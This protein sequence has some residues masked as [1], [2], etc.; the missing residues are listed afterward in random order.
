MNERKKIER[1]REELY[2]DDSQT[3][4]TIEVRHTNNRNS[5]KR[6]LNHA[7]INSEVTWTLELSCA[8]VQ[9]L[10]KVSVTP[11][12]NHWDLHLG[13]LLHVSSRNHVWCNEAVNQ[14]VVSTNDWLEAAHKVLCLH[15]ARESWSMMNLLSIDTGKHSMPRLRLIYK[16]CLCKGKWMIPY[17][18]E[19]NIAQ[20]S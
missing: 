5:N 4:A 16:R 12:L 19:R 8:L 20:C 3:W 15:N 17:Y 9:M 14:M 7:V 18:W 10:C 11:V 13:F 2:A 1:G 6:T